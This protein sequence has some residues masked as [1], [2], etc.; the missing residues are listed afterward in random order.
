MIAEL[1]KSSLVTR[2]LAA[3]FGILVISIAAV[4]VG[5]GDDNGDTGGEPTSAD[6]TAAMTEPAGDES[7]AVEAAFLAAIDAWNSKDVEGLMA[8]FTDAGLLS[9][10]D[11]TREEA[12]QFLPDFIGDPAITT[13]EL[14]VEVS[15]DTATLV[16]AEEAFGIFLEPA[17]YTLIKQGDAWL[18][19]SETPMDAEIPDETTAVDVSLLE[20]QFGY[21]AGA[22][23]SGDIAFAV[24]NI[25]GAEHELA[26]LTLDEGVDLETALPS[27][28]EGI[29][30]GVEVLG[31]GGPW[32][33]GDGGNLVLTET[34]PAGRYAMVCFLPSDDGTPHALLGMH[35]EFTI[36]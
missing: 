26:L 11:A 2:W 23:S 32:S 30:E 27:F 15:G 33:P 6:P 17:M 16:D 9:T 7:A 28:E 19:D 21:D 10:F 1:G 14:S 34:L 22:I 31:V 29:P 12:A 24:N 18:L 35:S 5:C 13:G 8:A 25:G 36:E 3:F 4:A 20:Y